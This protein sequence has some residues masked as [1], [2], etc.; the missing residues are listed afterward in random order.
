VEPRAFLNV[1]KRDSSLPSPVRNR[2]LGCPA[3][4]VVPVLS[5]LSAFGIVLKS[6]NFYS[7]Q[8]TLPTTIKFYIQKF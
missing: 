2:F 3:L 6:I 4:D 8:V 1:V 7:L 5:E